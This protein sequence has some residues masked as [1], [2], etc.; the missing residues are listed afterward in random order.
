MSSPLT[1]V[2]PNISRCRPFCI[3]KYKRQDDL[4]LWMA[5]FFPCWLRRSSAGEVGSEGREG[6]TSNEGDVA[7]GTL[8]RLL[9]DPSENCVFFEG[10]EVHQGTLGCILRGVW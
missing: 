7:C 6:G 5:L 10:K 1:L 4:A 8:Q 3:E 9:S 2:T